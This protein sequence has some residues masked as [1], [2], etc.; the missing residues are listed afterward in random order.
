MSILSVYIK[1]NMPSIR[2]YWSHIMSC[3]SRCECV[4][5]CIFRY[6]GLLSANI[7]VLEVSL[8]DQRLFPDGTPGV[9]VCVNSLQVGT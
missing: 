2:P 3:C 4:K 5:V 1:F 8:V 6:D 9:T 7:L